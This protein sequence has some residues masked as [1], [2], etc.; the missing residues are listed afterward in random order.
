MHACKLSNI[1]WNMIRWMIIS[2]SVV[3][4][5]MTNNEYVILIYYIFV[6]DEITFT[7]VADHNIV[8]KHWL[9]WAF[10]YCDFVC[11]YHCCC[12]CVGCCF[13]VM[14]VFL[15]DCLPKLLQNILQPTNWKWFKDVPICLSCMGVYWKT[16]LNC[17]KLYFLHFTQVATCRRH[18]SITVCFS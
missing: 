1:W 14:I 12:C 5:F 15:C 11:C 10:V 3:E 2:V 4:D 7:C 9:I 6:L 18:V 8:F 17:A 13:F 16:N